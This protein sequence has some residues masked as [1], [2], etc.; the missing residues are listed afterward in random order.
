MIE[1][2]NIE[3]LITEMQHLRIAASELIERSEVL[4]KKSDQLQ[5]KIL[6]SFCKHVIGLKLKSSPCRETSLPPQVSK[7]WTA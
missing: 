4:L 6:E 1:D 3:A 7:T 2:E 5:H